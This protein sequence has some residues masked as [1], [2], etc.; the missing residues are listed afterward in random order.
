MVHPRPSNDELLAEFHRVVLEHGRIPTWAVFG[1]KRKLGSEA[2][3]RKRFRSVAGL[4]QAYRAWLHVNQPESPALGLLAAAAP[5][6]GGSPKPHAPVRN[7]AGNDG[8]V[9]GPPLDFRGLRH[10]P[11]NEQ[12]VVYIF[13]MVSYEL[14]FIV[15]GLQSSFPDC[16]AMRRTHNDRWQRVR[17]EFEFKSRNFHQH[18][19]PPEAADLI[20]C[21]EHDLPDCPL[22]VL[23]LKSAI[24]TLTKQGD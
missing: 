2:L 17:I 7:W 11:I 18:G 20:V 1:N 13:G 4:W 21:W 8:P 23:E 15:E 10:A 9:F 5:R 14:G 16:E 19:H 3:L 12:G 6:T 24:K 22:E